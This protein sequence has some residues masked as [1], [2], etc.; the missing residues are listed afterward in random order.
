MKKAIRN[1]PNKQANDFCKPLL[2][3]LASELAKEYVR[4]IKQSVNA[5]QNEQHGEKYMRAAIYARCS[6]ESQRQESIEDQIFTCRRLAREKSFTV[7]DDHI[8][9]DYAQSGASKD[10]IGLNELIAA[11]AGKP[12]D[13]VLCR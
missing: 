2:D 11:S 9:S 5:K 12:F 3:H 4:L 1:V 7:L 6:S 10:R 13:V 8:Y